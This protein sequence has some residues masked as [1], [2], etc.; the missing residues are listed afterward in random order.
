[1]AAD[2][3]KIETP[4]LK[5]FLYMGMFAEELCFYLVVLGL[6]AMEDGM[7]GCPLQAR[8]GEAFGWFSHGA[9]LLYH[10]RRGGERNLEFT[11]QS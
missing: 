5:K 7:D 6:D 2:F 11:I 10:W 8:M 9:V 1:V 3:R 4:I